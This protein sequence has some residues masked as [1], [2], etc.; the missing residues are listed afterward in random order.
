MEGIHVQIAI[1]IGCGCHDARAC[2]D[3]ASGEVCSWLRV[4]YEVRRGVCSSCPDHVERWTSGVRTVAQGVSLGLSSEQRQQAV[5]RMLSKW[6]D[7]GFVPDAPYLAS[8]DRYVAG[9][10]SLRHVALPAGLQSACGDRS[11]E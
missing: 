1:C 4:D 8:L 10:L 2:V 3:H 9:E 7:A 11:A 5:D 6:K